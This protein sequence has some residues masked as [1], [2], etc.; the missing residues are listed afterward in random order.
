[1]KIFTISIFVI[2]L[3]F[4]IPH[5]F[6]ETTVSVSIPKGTDTPGCQEVD[7]CYIPSPLTINVGD[8]VEWINRDSVV[9][10]VA[11]GSPGDGPNGEIY[12]HLMKTGESFA[13]RFDEAGS[14]P[15]FCT[16]HPWMQG[17]VI[18]EVVL[19]S[20]DLLTEYE[21]M[22][23][24]ISSDGSTIITIHTNPPKAGD[25]LSIDLR[26]TDENEIALAH[27]N[28]DIKVIQDEEEILFLENAHSMDGTVEHLARAESDNPVDI[29]IGIRGIYPMSGESQP[30][31]EVI[32]FE[33]VPEF[34]VITMLILGLGFFVGFYFLNKYSSL[35]IPN[36]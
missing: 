10:T 29:E 28:Y 26:F 15:Y 9:H 6:A 7:L 14:Y 36:M 22:E 2:L 8:V 27:V 17:I 13:F 16:I 12:S 32:E 31:R 30:V 19:D 24:R 4:T 18:A 5:S 3:I 25:G 35:R 1:M 33:Q 20:Q 34:G 21:L 23:K 11:S